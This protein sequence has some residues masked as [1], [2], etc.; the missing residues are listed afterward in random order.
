[1]FLLT[2][3]LW[4]V[5]VGSGEAV[6]K[7]HNNGTF[8]PGFIFGAAVAAYQVE[9]AWNI[10]GK[11]ESIWDNFAHRV[12]SPIRDNDTGDIA[13]DSYHKYKQD[14]RLAAELGL[15]MYRF[16]V[17]WSRILPTG[18]ANNINQK[19]LNYYKNL[20]KEI[21]K[22]NMIP[23]ATIYHW[24]LPQK[25]YEDGIDWTT[26]DLIPH[27]VDFARIVI[28][29]LP[30]VG[31]WLTIN[32]PKQ[33][34][35]LGY[36]D[37]SFA[38][39]IKSDGL[40]E[41]QCSYV[42]IKGHAAIYHMYKK[43]FPKRTAKMS[44]AIDCQWIEPLNNT[45]ENE[46]A[47]ERQRQF[48]CGLYFH[49]IFKGDWP[50]IVK[51]RISERSKAANY[52]KSRLPELTKEEIEYVKGTHDFLGLN[53]Y[54][55][56]LARD[57]KEAAANVTSFCADVGVVDSFDSAWAVEANG[58]FV[59]VPFGIYKV[60]K[61]LVHEYGQQEI[62]ITELGMA[63]DGTYL[64]DFDRIDFYWDYLCHVI[65]AIDEGVNVVG[66][67]IW[68]LIDNLEWIYGYSAH[69]GIY[70][71][72]FNDPERLRLP[73]LSASFFKELIKSNALNCGKPRR[74]W[75]GPIKLPAYEPSKN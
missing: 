75:P 35:H 72:D 36:G 7:V 53:H 16:S 17:A 20:V 67:I 29:N 15:K 60:L 8:P 50:E 66:V 30:E 37:G 47:A 52:S 59:I 41:Y 14:V 28:K 45:S 4:F 33:V 38:P 5:F 3:L 34:C 24:D 68:S 11:G 73:K 58:I 48:E 46:A 42:L 62:L 57:T 13:C 61:W 65:Q 56:M 21:R 43:E 39:G 32:E 44:L 10:D 19:G 71:I 63:D 6:V 22:F 51:K 69:F 49:P 25:L 18:Y 74:H 64:I 23:V 9:G 26:T 54:I 40:L 70:H 55:T 2:W 1:M 12:P 27:L 31:V